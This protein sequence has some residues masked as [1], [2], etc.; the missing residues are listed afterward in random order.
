MSLRQTAPFG[1][2]KTSP[3]SFGEQGDELFAQDARRFAGQPH[4]ATTGR[5]LRRN[6][7]P[8][9]RTRLDHEDSPC[10]V[11]RTIAQREELTLPQPGQTRESDQIAAGLDRLG[12]EVVH[13][14]PGEE[15]HLGPLT[16]RRPHPQDALVDRLASLLRAAQDHLERVEHQ[17]GCARRPSCDR[18][19]VI[20]DIRRTDR[21]ELPAVED[22]KSAQRVATARE[23]RRPRTLGVPLEPALDELGERLRLRRVEHAEGDAPVDLVA[24]DLR[25]P[26][27]SSKG[28]VRQR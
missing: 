28:I 19:D 15:A 8:F 21:L 16:T 20:L 26:L 4:A 3:D 24:D 18:E 17:L 10:E 25:V 12:G 9:A 27:P 22:G 1:V 23:R 7:P 2:G 14:A 5:G 13:L 11:N 6:E